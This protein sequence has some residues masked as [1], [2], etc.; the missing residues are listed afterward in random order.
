MIALTT[1]TPTRVNQTNGGGL[2]TR[3][4]KVEL[5][6]FA[7][8]IAICNLPGMLPVL[9][10]IPAEGQWWRLFTH[11]FTHVTWYHLLLDG[12][13]FLFLYASLREP[14]RSYRL[15][16]V[17]AGIAGSLFFA[18][19]ATQTLGFCG[20]SGVAHGLMAV[21]ALELIVAGDKAGWPCL[22]LVAG[23]ALWETLTGHVF[24]EFLHFGL[25]GSPIAVSHL[26]GVIG[27]VTM[28]C[29]QRLSQASYKFT[30]TTATA[31]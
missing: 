30:T 1:T 20:L 27:G 11:A 23:K 29:V 26:G 7:L 6:A 25:M 3:P 4:H 19:P 31:L 15:G 28:F 10:F 18:W 2:I 17:V 16:Y 13:A 22:L 12:T 5:I 21:T 9:R 8:I 24:F 14:R